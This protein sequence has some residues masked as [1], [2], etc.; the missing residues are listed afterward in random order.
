MFYL[1]I[2]LGVIIGGVSAGFPGAVFGGCLGLLLGDRADLRQRISQLEQEM[3]WVRKTV[4]AQQAT[5]AKAKAAD[6]IPDHQTSPAAT[7]QPP[8]QSE[9][10]APQIMTAPVAPVAQAAPKAATQIQAAQTTQAEQT[11]QAAQAAQAATQDDGIAPA[12]GSGPNGAQV[13]DF[14]FHARPDF[15]APQ[16]PSKG[17]T[18]PEPSPFTDAVVAFFTGGNLLVKAGIIILFFGVSFLVKYAAEQG[19]FPIQLRLAACALGG[20]ALLCTGWTLRKRRAEYSLTLQGGGI[21]VLYLTCYATF[22]LYHLMPEPTAF[23]VLLAISLLCS[24]LAVAQDSRTLA[25]FGISG[26]FLAPLLAS[27]GHGNHQFLFGYYLVLNLG[28]IGIAWFK[29]WRQL[30]LAG[31]SF[32]FLLGAVWGANYYSPA[33]FASTEPFLVLFFLIY[34]AVAVLFAYRQPPELKGYLDGTIIFG[35]PIVCFALQ[36]CLVADYRYGLAW[37]ALAAG[38]LYTTLFW[39]LSRQG[40]AMEP[41]AEA[42]LAFGVIFFTLTIPLACDGRWTAAAWAVEGAAIAW[43]GIRQE[44]QAAR[45]FGYLLQ[46]GAGVAFCS[47][48]A[49]PA[50]LLP[51]LNVFYLGC[52]LISVSGLW[53]AYTLYRES[54]KV[55]GWEYILSQLLIAWGLFWW[56]GGGLSEINNHLAPAWLAG[57]RLFLVAATCGLCHLVE[58]HF[59]WEP[60][61]WPALGI[62]PALWCFAFLGLSVHPLENGAWLVWPAAFVLLYTVLYLRDDEHRELLPY[63]HGAALWLVCVLATWEFGWQIRHFIGSAGSWLIISRGLVPAL[64][65]LAL[66][67]FGDLFSWPVRRHEETYFTLAAVPLAVWSLFWIIYVSLTDP[68]DPAPFSWLPLLNP[69]DVACGLS[70]CALGLWCRRFRQFVP[71]SL[72]GQLDGLLAVAGAATLFIWTN[73]ILGRG[74]HYWG[75][76]PFD[77]ASLFDSRLAQTSFAIYWSVLALCSMIY[78][79]QRGLRAAWLAGAG[80]LGVVVVKLF[81]IDLAGRGSIERIVSF[82]AVGLLLLVIGWF[83]PVPPKGGE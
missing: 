17:A 63:L 73:S 29:S 18:P 13:N 48:L 14:V 32:T 6:K 83:S 19:L 45:F 43:V 82:V 44:R 61:S 68:G 71:D 30:N 80:L 75:G 54:H 79:T 12:P 33:F 26:G 69:L 21:G 5:S 2:A 20:V 49:R 64:A 77:A 22:R 70:F 47:E 46:A 31:F 23:A 36:A 65:L 81:L 52:T 66:A 38:L 7:D 55:A 62:V 24:T 41:L 78:A 35:T 16:R 60:L 37:S 9:P 59:S 51:V 15:A 42:F 76:V 10:I 74:L 28:V 72:G 25:L 58:R 11:K 53:T 1:F 4:A 40:R 50:G 39:G 34:L 67:Q 3:V 57:G 27:V 8:R 56:L